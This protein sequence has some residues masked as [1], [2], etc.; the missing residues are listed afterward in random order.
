MVH[1]TGLGSLRNFLDFSNKTVLVTGSTR[2]IGKAIAELFAKHGATV[3][4]N[5]RNEEDVELVVSDFRAHGFCAE[6]IAADVGNE[7]EVRA[8]IGRIMKTLGRLD[9][10]INNAA[11]RPF[12]AD[13]AVVDAR[14]LRET[15]ETN[16]IGTFNVARIAAGVMKEQ[17]HGS[18]VNI[19]SSAAIDGSEVAGLD[20][21][22]SK[23]AILSLTR[24][25]ARQFGSAGIRVNA[26]IPCFTR[27]ERRRGVDEG[28]L[29]AVTRDSFL[30]RLASPVEVASVC[31]FLASDLASYVTGEVIALGGFLKPTIDI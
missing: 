7:E 8:M 31:L 18:I 15:L 19:S 5:S 29:K 20:Y 25:L 11:L 28:I 14:S 23:G 13:G 17:K 24:G 16:V 4:I 26:V 6:G 30:K 22:T 9:V 10:G 1:H 3:I 2:N 12:D 21:I 27:T